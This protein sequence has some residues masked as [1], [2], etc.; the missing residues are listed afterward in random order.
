MNDI[1]H[2][3]CSRVLNRTEMQFLS[4]VGNEREA[5]ALA[6]VCHLPDDATYAQ[7]EDAVL[8]CFCS[9]LEYAG[10]EDSI[11]YVGGQRRDTLRVNQ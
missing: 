7:I 11:Q 9:A 6:A 10:L 1:T 8:K 2:Q 5:I 4:Y 3:Q